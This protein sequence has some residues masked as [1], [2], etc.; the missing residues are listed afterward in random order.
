MTVDRGDEFGI[1]KNTTP[2]Q[3]EIVDL[4]DARQD[5]KIEVQSEGDEHIAS[6]VLDIGH[7][8]IAEEVI[9][10]ENGETGNIAPLPLSLAASTRI[11]QLFYEPFSHRNRLSIGDINALVVG[12]KELHGEPGEEVDDI[13]LDTSLTML[14]QGIHKKD[15]A[16]KT[17]RTPSE[18]NRLIALFMRD[19]R[20][21]IIDNRARAER[22]MIAIIEEDRAETGRLPAPLRPR[23]PKSVQKETENS[24]PE[25][26]IEPTTPLEPVKKK[27]LRPTRVKTVQSAG[28][29]KND[30]PKL[31]QREALVSSVSA[32]ALS[33]VELNKDRERDLFMLAL[34]NPAV[35]RNYLGME[36]KKS[37]EGARRENAILEGHDVALLRDITGQEVGNPLMKA[38]VFGAR[39]LV[40]ELSR[41]YPGR[42][43]ND[44]LPNIVVMRGLLYNYAQRNMPISMLEKASPN[45]PVRLLIAG[46]IK[47]VVDTVV[48]AKKRT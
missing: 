11:D 13:F 25:P 41:A 5:D 48:K 29:D 19:V 7:Q 17:G 4:D 31:E 18:V 12:L 14:L 28:A 38:D 30:K 3:A 47:E 46:A 32:R 44:D 43:A 9:I 16:G 35:G 8:A 45:V 34:K 33:A 20:K 23:P 26:T 40:V 21:T 42:L 24:K 27:A 22:R 1:A 15:I 2:F 39:A 10:P 37:L 36:M 6:Q